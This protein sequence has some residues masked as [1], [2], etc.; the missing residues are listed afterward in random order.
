MRHREIPC[1]GT[2]KHIKRRQMPLNGSEHRTG[3][4]ESNIVLDFPT[5]CPCLNPV[6]NGKNCGRVKLGLPEGHPFGG[7]VFKEPR[8]EFRGNRITRNNSTRVYQTGCRLNDEIFGKRT[9]G[10]MAVKTVLLKDKIRLLCHVLLCE[11]HRPP[12]EDKC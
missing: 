5:G 1:E 7:V 2:V 4:N 6:S 10:A 3:C 11:C 8:I 12:Y 9:V